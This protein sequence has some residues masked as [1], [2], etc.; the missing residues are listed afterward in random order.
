MFEFAHNGVTFPF[1][2]TDAN[3]AERYEDAAERLMEKGKTAPKDGKKSAVLRYLCEAYNAFFDELFGDGASGKLFGES[4]SVAERE[5]AYIALLDAVNAQ[6]EEQMQRRARYMPN[7][8]QR[9]AKG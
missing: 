3:V 1:D 5:G 8:A 2:M 6:N 9:R 7:R 4:M